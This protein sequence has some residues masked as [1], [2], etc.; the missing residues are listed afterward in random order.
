VWYGLLAPART[1]AKIIA[2]LNA[3]SRRVL[4]MPDVKEKLSRAGI[5]TAGGTPDEFA[6]FIRAEY[7]KW[8][9]VV[10]AAGVKAN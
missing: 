3:E 8:G 7:E 2:K 4:T 9:P 10:K 5:D 6:K 1:P